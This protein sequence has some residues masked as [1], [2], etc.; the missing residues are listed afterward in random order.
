MDG[1]GLVRDW[2]P[3]A[4]DVFGYSWHEAT[5]QELAELIIPPAYRDA[6]RAAYTR[7]VRTREP[8]ILD[9]RM[10]L[11]ALRRGGE[12][13]PV[14]LTVTRVPDT[15]P[16]LFA[17]FVRDLTERVRGEE[18]SERLQRRMAFLAHAGLMLDVSLDLDE[19]LRN[20]VQLTVP[21]LAELAVIDLVTEHGSIRGAVAAT[22]DDPERA[23]A[24]EEMRR[25]HPLDLHGAHPVAQVMRTRESVLLEAMSDDELRAYA[26]SDEHFEL[27][28]RLRYRSAI[29]VPLLARSRLVGAL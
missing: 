2:N 3:A 25:N 9:R 5:G 23:A 15:E 24:L 10:E 29:V 12:E 16:P 1:D 13:F 19:T 7:Y 27:M 11:T 28:Q 6:H 17:G 14:E 21:E 18:A 26:Q 8:M 4:E 22:A 20:L